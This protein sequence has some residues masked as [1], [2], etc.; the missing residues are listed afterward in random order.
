VH[1]GVAL[2]LVTNRVR[3]HLDVETRYGTGPNPDQAFII[4]ID[5][6]DIFDG[7]QYLEF[8]ARPFQGQASHPT[9]L[10][11]LHELEIEFERNVSTKIDELIEKGDDP[12]AQ[13]DRDAF[14]H[15][16]E[17]LR[18]LVARALQDLGIEVT[19]ASGSK[20]QQAYSILKTPISPIK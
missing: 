5:R 20:Y 7:Q 8:L 9:A 10:G 19:E 15:D 11:T 3:V 12:L 13:R 6:T 14:L 18:V 16:Q 2:V 4:S 1:F 17:T